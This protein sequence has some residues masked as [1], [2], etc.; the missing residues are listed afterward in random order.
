M[1]RV[2]T[3]TYSAAI[4]SSLLGKISLD[5]HVLGLGLGLPG[6]I[7]PALAAQLQAVAQP[8]DTAVH[9]LLETLGIHLGEADVRVHGVRC[10]GAVLVE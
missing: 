8:L 1:K 3:D 5:V 9:D 6:A 2:E 10:G 7:G 4:V